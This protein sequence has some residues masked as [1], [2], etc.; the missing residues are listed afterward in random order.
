MRLF[1]KIKSLFEAII[2]SAA[3]KEVIDYVKENKWL[4]VILLY[5]ILVHFMTC[6]AFCMG[7]LNSTIGNP[8]IQ[9]LW[10][11]LALFGIC[12]LP[13]GMISRLMVSLLVIIHT[14]IGVFSIF[15]SLVFSL[16]VRA[17]AFA[18]LA[19]SSTQEI[20]EFCSVFLR[21]KVLFL[22]FATVI[23]VAML[24][25]AVWK[26]SI[27]R[28]LC[29]YVF[30]CILIFPQII[31][32]VR[33]AA[34]KDYE[35]IYSKN[36]IASLIYEFMSYRESVHK[37]TQ[38][39]CRPQIP[40]G[41]DNHRSDENFTAVFV[42]GESATRFHHSIYG[43]P[44]KTSPLLEAVKDKLF[45]FTDVISA[46]AHTVASLSFM[47]T[48]ED[49]QHLGDYRYTM[50]DIFK[51]AG[52]QIYFYS[53]QARWGEYDSPISILTAHA[54]KRVF[55]QEE[56][57][58]ALDNGLLKYFAEALATKGRKLI[59]L[60]L[61]GSHGRYDKRSPASFKVFNPSNRL[62]SPY[63][64]DHWDEIDE[65]DNSIRFTDSIL[66]Q[67]VDSLEK[68]PA[69]SFML[70]C[71]DHGDFS[72][73]TE[74]SPRSGSS[75]SPE[76]YEIPFVFYANPAFR[77]RYG[78]FL[79]DVRKNVDKPFLTDQV[80][81]PFL[82]AAQISFDGFPKNVDLFSPGYVPIPERQLGRSGAF[83]HSR[84][85]PYKKPG[86]N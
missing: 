78:A 72:E 85:N 30:A 13:G 26:S 11:W 4:G 43:Y 80:M 12:L 22:L 2:N 16:K 62:E 7:N 49:T 71:S 53:N 25:I 39:A 59:V 55:L 56:S 52:F 77:G 48:T 74:K 75:T 35:S 3:F 84:T 34:R 19:V 65:Y 82:S 57:P 10:S 27:R 1:K 50:F 23:V 36:P 47:L 33:L 32:M 14:L 5:I 37:I 38:M 6:V 29:L 86:K 69:A 18:V 21:A 9:G 54:D 64:V 40:K 24:L 79:N 58:G 67:I 83:Y 81:F 28:K 76:F 68:N 61:M 60:H 41:I 15:F 42:I 31:D 44:R 45:I 70:Y 66:G 51:A 17:D 46:Y 20:R 8:F 63:Q 73:R